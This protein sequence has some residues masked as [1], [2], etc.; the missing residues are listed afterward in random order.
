MTYPFT[1]VNN[2]GMKKNELQF[3]S[4]WTTLQNYD[5]SLHWSTCVV[6]FRIWKCLKLFL[7]CSISEIKWVQLEVI[8]EVCLYEKRLYL[9]G[10]KVVGMENGKYLATKELI[11]LVSGKT[12]E[13]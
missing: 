8:G 11:K 6:F 12:E 2:K 13:V 7:R 1:A 4:A 3:F 10:D 5:S 9:N